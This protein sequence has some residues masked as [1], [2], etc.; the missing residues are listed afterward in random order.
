MSH[1][2]IITASHVGQRLDIFCVGR[3]PGP[4]RTA[5]Q[6]AIKTGQITVNDKN[7]KPN[8]ALKDQD[9]IDISLDDTTKPEPR[10]DVKLKLEVI[11]EDKDVVAINKPAGLLVHSHPRTNEAAVVDWL[12]AHFP[13]IKNV[14]E[15]S[16]RP[17][18]VHRLDK[19][20]SGVLIIAKTS[21][22]FDHL[23]EEFK[24]HRPKKEYLALVFGVPHA[25]DGRINQPISRNPKNPSRRAIHSEGK[26]AITEWKIEKKYD[27][28]AL[29]RLFP[30]TGRTHQLRVHL[31]HI[32]HPI[33]G[34][35]L[36]VFKRQKS[37]P[38][39]TRQLLHAEKLTIRLPSGKRKTIQAPL[40]EDFARVVSSLGN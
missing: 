38:G 23:R 37:P 6:K 40:P 24:R 7:T 12:I 35:H 30:Y 22:A 8:Y 29:L 2:V 39:V 21:S 31:H 17:G 28:Y 11:Y 10:T 5:I 27:K 1:Q 9:I 16:N 33:V 34:D 18:L 19:D 36:Y 25:A 15:D 26:P 3:L 4:S 20:T 14:G 32:S 13:E